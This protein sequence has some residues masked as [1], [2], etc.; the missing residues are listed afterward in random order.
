MVYLK[1]N[2]PKYNPK[3]TP[4]LNMLIHKLEAMRVEIKKFEDCINDHSYDISNTNR[5]FSKVNKGLN[6][7]LKYLRINLELLGSSIKQ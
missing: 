1:D 4:E 5:L 7:Q 3:L 2:F 6:E